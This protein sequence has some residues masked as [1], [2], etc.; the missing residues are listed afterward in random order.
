MTDPVYGTRSA[1]LHDVASIIRDEVLALVDEG[2]PY[3]QLDNPHYPDYL[4]DDRNA[5][6]RAL[7][8]D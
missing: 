8:V 1:A 6:W 7:G 4:M 2:L 5:Q 3:V